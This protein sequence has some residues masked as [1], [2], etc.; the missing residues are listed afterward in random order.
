MQRGG[1]LMT[2]EEVA[3]E[4][5]LAIHR[6]APTE[7]ISDYCEHVADGHEATF[8]EYLEF[9]IQSEQE[10]AAEDRQVNGT[11]LFRLMAYIK[12]WKK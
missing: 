7:W 3:T 8:H 4:V 1:L 6:G 9:Q 10:A 12:M 2:S 11:Y 5:F